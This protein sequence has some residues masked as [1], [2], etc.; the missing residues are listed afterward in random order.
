MLRAL[1]PLPDAVWGAGPPRGGRAS[2]DVRVDRRGGAGRAAPGRRARRGDLLGDR[3]HRV[4]TRRGSVVQTGRDQERGVVRRKAPVA[5]RQHVLEPI[6]SRARGPGR[7][8][9]RIRRKPVAVMQPRRRDRRGVERR[10]DLA[11][12]PRPP[13]RR[14]PSAARRGSGA[15]AG[16]GGCRATRPPHTATSPLAASVSASSPPERRPRSRSLARRAAAQL[17]PA[18]LGEVQRDMSGRSVQPGSPRRASTSPPGSTARST[19]RSRSAAAARIA[20]TAAAMC[21]RLERL[22]PSLVARVGVHR[23]GAGGDA[24]PRVRGQLVR[25]ARDAGARSPFRQA[26]RTMPP[27]RTPRPAAPRRSGTSSACRPAGSAERG[28]EV[29][30]EPAGRRQRVQAAR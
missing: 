18:L 9:D 24:R 7:V 17:V 28:G 4:R 30:D 3:Y 25:R 29:A 16:G 13:P 6:R 1:R 12:R 26:W 10:V 14:S 5:Q 23:A 19:A 11:P 2:V 27:A 22:V 20:R 15:P 8:D 21:A